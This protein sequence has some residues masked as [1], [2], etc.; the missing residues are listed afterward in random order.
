[1]SYTPPTPPAGLPTDIDDTLNGYSS[2]EL[3]DVA[4]Y[5]EA[6]ANTRSVRPDSRKSRIKTRLPIWLPS[7][8]ILWVWFREI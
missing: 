3:Q 8:D 7:V 4:R 2:D 6:L 5:A 1:M